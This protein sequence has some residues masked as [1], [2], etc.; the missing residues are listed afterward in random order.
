MKKIVIIFGGPVN[1]FDKGLGF[2]R[3]FERKFKVKEE[4]RRSGK[5]DM[6]QNA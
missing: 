6:A 2:F 1:L 3:Y 4:N 5:P